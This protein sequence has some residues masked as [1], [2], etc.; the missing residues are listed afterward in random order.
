M[1]ARDP[2]QGESTARELGV[3]FHRLDV[4]DTEHAVAL[5]DWL[6]QTYGRLDLLVN[7][8]GVLLDRKA[9]RVTMKLEVLEQSLAA[10]ICRLKAIQG[11]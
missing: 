8:A 6:N 4:L 7:N 11:F 3:R 5:A 10:S 2:L 9:K 1:T